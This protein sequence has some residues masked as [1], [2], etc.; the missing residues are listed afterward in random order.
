MKKLLLGLLVFTSTLG[1][2]QQ[3]PPKLWDKTYGG[4][5]SEIA[6]KIIHTRNNQILTAG[7]SYS[8]IGADKTQDRKGVNGFTDFWVVKMDSVGNKL[9]DKTYGGRYTDMFRTGIETSDGGFLLGGYSESDISGDKSQAGNGGKDFWIIKIDADGNKLWD[10]TFGGTRDEDLYSIVETATGDFLIGGSSDSR[11]TG[12]KTEDTRD[13]NGL[14]TDFWIVKVSSTGSKIWDKTYG[15]DSHDQLRAIVPAHN[16]GFLLVGTTY[17][18]AGGEKSDYL[19]GNYNLGA[20]DYWA[21]RINAN[22]A[23]LWDKSY[24]GSDLDDVKT[25]IKTSRGYLLGGGSRS[26]FSFEKTDTCRG[27]FDS[28]LVHID[29]TGVIIWDKTLGGDGEDN[30]DAVVEQI[31]G[32]FIY[33][34][35]SGSGR[36]GDKTQ[37]KMSWFDYWVVK[38]NPNGQKVWDGTYGGDQGDYCYS[39]TLANDNGI[40]VTGQSMSGI[41]GNKSQAPKG[42]SDYWTI[43][44]RNNLLSARFTHDTLCLG[45]T[46]TIQYAI[47]GF[48]NN[49]NKFRFQL[50]DKNGSFSSPIAIDSL[51]LAGSGSFSGSLNIT[52]PAIMLTGNQYKLRVISTNPGDTMVSL[53]FVIKNCCDALTK[54]TAF[55]RTGELYNTTNCEGQSIALESSVVPNATGYVWRG[56]NGFIS[57]AKDTTIQNITLVNSGYYVVYATLGLCKSEADSVLVNV[58]ARPARPEITNDGPYNSGAM[59]HLFANTTASAYEWTGPSSFSATVQNPMI[60]N[61]TSAN[62]GTYYLKVANAE[63]WSELGSTVV[64]VDNISSIQTTEMNTFKVYPNPIKTGQ[65]VTVESKNNTTANFKMVDVSGK[66]IK[67]GTINGVKS[68]INTNEMKGIYFLEINENGKT[69]TEKIVIE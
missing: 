61:A 14:R 11:N 38:L 37:D 57:H 48:Y 1:F 10:A 33:A 43:K 51:T 16:G 69:H 5:D 13:P 28:W 32:S 12:D 2:G 25:A 17:S 66:T 53:P 65:N 7:I 21:V 44:L 27:S 29:T 49:G 47:R 42:S 24:G 54:P 59:I 4:T 34:T 35:S 46:A 8:G 41:S 15:S 50:S 68:E 20:A 3:R 23:K 18:N 56:P 58:K 45:S 9:W 40:L 63:C 36:T 26:P 30:T 52:I 6:Y 55:N 22:G 31:D 64:T 67:S 39:M 60:N 19:R 62:A